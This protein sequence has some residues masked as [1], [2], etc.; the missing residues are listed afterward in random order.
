MRLAINYFQICNILS[1]PARAGLSKLVV[2]EDSRLCFLCLLSLC[3]FG[4]TF[5]I[6]QFFSQFTT[7]FYICLFV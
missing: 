7:A 4:L 5:Y 3:A 2:Y 1:I 6:L